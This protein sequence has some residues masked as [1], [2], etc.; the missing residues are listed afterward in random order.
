ME[1]RD[2]RTFATVARTLNFRRT[3]E[4]LN[5]AQSTVSARI[6]SLED[7]LGVRL[8][9]RLGAKVV[10]T[11]TGS[12]LLG[13]AQKMLDL[14]DEARAWVMDDT[15][16]RGSLTVRVP[17]SLCTHRLGGAIRAF[18]EQFPLIKLNFITCTLDGLEKDLRLGVTD[19]AFVYMDAV[20]AADLRVEYLGSEPLILASAPDHPM[21]RMRKVLPE[22]FQGVSLLL[23]KGDCSY[24]RMFEGLL[25]EC[26][27]ETGVGME[28]SSLAALEQCLIAGLGVTIIPEV[29]VR[30]DLHNGSL[31]TLAWQGEPLETGILMIR[32]KEKWLSPPL[33]AFMELVKVEM[34]RSLQGTKIVLALG[35]AGS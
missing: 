27:V 9:D 29:T 4:C 1:L 10:L 25:S 32:H 30:G 11:E 15:E 34:A 2:L 13:Y 26:R 12:R 28:F 22:A 20:K 35:S 33:R 19:L 7:E 17:E 24:R 16:I 3:S 31:V 21:A 14:E 8:F 6:A 23:A 18:R 5:T